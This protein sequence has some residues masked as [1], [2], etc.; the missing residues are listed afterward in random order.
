M[1][2]DDDY[3]DVGDVR[4][5]RILVCHGDDEPTEF[6]NWLESIWSQF[7]GLQRLSWDF[8]IEL[9]S[10][11]YK[12]TIINFQD[13]FDLCGIE[14]ENNSWEG[15]LISGTY[16]WCWVEEN[17]VQDTIIRLGDVLST[18]D[19]SIKT[20]I[21]TNVINELKNLD[22]LDELIERTT[23]YSEW[24]QRINKLQEENKRLK[25]QQTQRHENAIDSACLEIL[26]ALLTRNYKRIV[27]GPIVLWEDGKVIVITSIGGVDIPTGTSISLV[28]ETLKASGYPY[29]A[30]EEVSRIRSPHTGRV[31]YHKGSFEVSEWE[32]VWYQ[33]RLSGRVFKS[34]TP[35][36]TELAKT[37]Y[38]VLST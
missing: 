12:R 34:A 15:S 31:S 24:A 16:Y 36:N 26:S 5:G 27:A 8:N 13:L 38:K 11:K 7:Q 10:K 22:D 1:I 9:I 30:I 2:E 33:K 20:K 14:T 3:P 25:E 21:K 32:N 19:E 6:I 4:D 18:L 23:G 29:I 28:Y 17:K 37:I 35:E